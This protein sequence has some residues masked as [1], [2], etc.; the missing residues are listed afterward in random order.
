MRGPQTTTELARLLRNMPTSTLYRQLARLRKAGLLRVVK[1]RQ[2]R[3]ATERTYAVLS[4]NSAAF[5]SRELEKVPARELRAALRNF[6]TTMATDFC[7]FIESR[8]FARGHTRVN[9]GLTICR[10]TDTEYLEVVKKVNALIMHAKSSSV[11]KPAAKR[12]YFYI[13]A[14]PEMPVL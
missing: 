5:G 12:R 1:E 6:I 7:T 14:L 8:A 10:L 2:A 13:V 9:A 4:R 11:G 3:G